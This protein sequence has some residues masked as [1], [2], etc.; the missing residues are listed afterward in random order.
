[1][2]ALATIA[3]TFVVIIAALVFLSFS[4]CAIASGGGSGDRLTFA[5]I[6][7]VALLILVGAQFRIN[8]LN[9]KD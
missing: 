1:M 9:R 3:L 5:F 6:A 7:L 2:K 8:K 4:L